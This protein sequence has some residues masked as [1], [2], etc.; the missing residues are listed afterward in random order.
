MGGFTSFS[1]I[2]IP[3]ENKLSIF[4]HIR[5]TSRI[6]IHNFPLDQNVIKF[7]DVSILYLFDTTSINLSAT[8]FINLGY[9]MK[10]IGIAPK[11]VFYISFFHKNS[12]WSYNIDKY[13]VNPYGNFLSNII[14]YNKKYIATLF[15]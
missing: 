1:I 11:R 15:N 6:I 2:Y 14:S 5:N 4:F 8:R 7:S 10:L 9:K 13:W 3:D 12:K